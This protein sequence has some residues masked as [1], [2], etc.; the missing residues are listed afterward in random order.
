[1]RN[2][3]A[4]SLLFLTLL[5]SA[6][7]AQSAGPG[8]QFDH[9]TTGYELTGAHRLQPC[10][11]CHVDAVFKGTPRAC[12]TCH[13]PGSRIGATPHEG[14]YVADGAIVP[15]SLGVNPFFTISAMTKGGAFF[16]AGVGTAGK[17]EKD[18]DVGRFTVTQQANDWAA[19]KVPTLRNVSRSAPY[20]HDGSAAKLEDA[21]QYMAA[22]AQANKNLTPLLASKNLTDAEKA[23]LVDFLHGLDCGLKLDEPKLP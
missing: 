3:L 13:S 5:A 19:F 4:S 21:V 1:M 17:E 9:L 10:E 12:F 7:F 22:G 16:N 20:F 15:T 23:D 8:K 11:S 18:V 2:I 14:L 6:A